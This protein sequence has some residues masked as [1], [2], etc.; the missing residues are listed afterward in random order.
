LRWWHPKPRRPCS[1]CWSVGGTLSY[2]ERGR[3]SAQ[4]AA[5]YKSLIE[6]CW[7]HTTLHA[8]KLDRELTYL[9]TGYNP[10]SFGEQLK[11]LRSELGD[12][13]L[14]HLEFLR[15]KEGQFNCSGLELVRF[16]SAERLNA[17]MDIYRKHGVQ[18]NNPH[19]YVVATARP[20]TSS[21]PLLQTK[22]DLDPESAQ[23]RKASQRSAAGLHSVRLR[24]TCTSIVPAARCGLY[25]V[26][27][28]LQWCSRAAGAERR[29]GIRA[30]PG[31]KE[32]AAPMPADPRPC[33]GAGTVIALQVLRSM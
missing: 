20:T 31:P 23:S 15:T 4:P 29:K 3:W 28:A 30:A 16:S 33:R 1:Y 17:I 27:A 18:I 21:I 7:N 11:A 19:V 26:H 6:Y 9:Q 22:A 14:F 5:G 25:L 13:V 32:A 12:E 24:R 10:A 2:C 8:L